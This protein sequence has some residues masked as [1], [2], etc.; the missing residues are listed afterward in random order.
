MITSAS[1]ANRF[2]ILF[3]NDTMRIAVLNNVFSMG[4][5]GRYK[6]AMTEIYNNASWRNAVSGSQNAKDGLYNAASANSHSLSQGFSTRWSYP[7]WVSATYSE[8][9]FPAGG[10]SATVTVSGFVDSPTSRT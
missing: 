5:I 10:Y 6:T 4:V 8:Y 7:N 1:D 2:K 3:N 9:D